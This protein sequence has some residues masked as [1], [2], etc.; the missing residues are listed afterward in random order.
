MENQT[1]VRIELG[2]DARNFIQQ[3]QI[4]NNIIE[5]QIS[6]GIEL[7]INDICEGNN[8]IESVRKS[9]KNEINLNKKVT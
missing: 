5:E 6:K 8:F 4:N 7:A 3:I 1:N 2:I 9:T